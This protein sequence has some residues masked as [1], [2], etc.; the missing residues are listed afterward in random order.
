MDHYKVLGLYRTASKEEIKAAFK[1]LAFQFHP[2]K[3][4]QSPKAVRENAT[5]RFKQVS[6]AYEVLMDDRKRADYNFRRSSGAGPETT[7]IL[8]T[9]TDTVGAGAVTSIINL[10]LVA[11]ASRPSLNSLFGF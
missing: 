5:I 4:S 9:A 2:D 11:V 7:T 1:K 6:E 3:H 10:G 8:S